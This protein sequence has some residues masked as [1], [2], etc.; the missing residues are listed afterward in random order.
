LHLEKPA[1]VTWA[2]RR[3]NLKRIRGKNQDNLLNETRKFN[4]SNSYIS[5]DKRIKYTTCKGKQLQTININLEKEPYLL[6]RIELCIEGVNRNGFYSNEEKLRFIFDNFFVRL[7]SGE[8]V[9]FY[10]RKLYRTGF[11]SGEFAL[12]GGRGKE[13]LLEWKDNFLKEIR[14]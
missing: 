12:N 1:Q 3:Y 14:I 10:N 2:L 11:Y 6:R 8:Y 9:F 5:G 7:K 4:S 13:R